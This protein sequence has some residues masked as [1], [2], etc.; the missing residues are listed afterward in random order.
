MGIGQNTDLFRFGMHDGKARC[1]KAGK[2][3]H[4]PVDTKWQL[5]V[6]G[7]LQVALSLIIPGCN[8]KILMAGYA[9]FP[10]ELSGTYL[11]LLEFL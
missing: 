7:G 3:V 9:F 11:L 2:D 8:T 5:C 10:S 1:T 6:L 4:C